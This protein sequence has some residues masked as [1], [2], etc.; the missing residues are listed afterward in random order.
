MGDDKRVSPLILKFCAAL[1]LSI[2]G[3]AYTMMI[4]KRNKGSQSGLCC[5]KVCL[6]LLELLCLCF[7]MMNVFFRL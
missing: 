5:L 6:F 4:N 7:L 1:A 3:V 2:G